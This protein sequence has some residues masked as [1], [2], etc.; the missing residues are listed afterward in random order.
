MPIVIYVYKSSAYKY[1]LKIIY[2]NDT[3]T[4]KNLDT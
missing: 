1:Q 4:V 2:Y 3:K